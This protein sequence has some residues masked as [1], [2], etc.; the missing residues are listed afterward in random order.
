MHITVAKFGGSENVLTIDIASDLSLKDLKAV[1]EAESDFGIKADEMSLFYEGKFLED[2]SKTLAQC[3]LNDYDLITCQRSTLRNGSMPEATTTLRRNMDA[4]DPRQLFEMLRSNSEMLQQIRRNSPQLVDAIQRGDFN[5][6]MEQIAAQSPEMQQRMELDRLASLD[7]FDPEVQRRIHDIINMQ[8]VQENMEHAVEHAP[9]VFGH[10]AMLYINCKVN[11][12]VVKAFVDSGAQ[13]T[14][15]SKA[16]A[17]RCGIMRLVDRRFSGIAKG[18]GTQ[19]ILGRIHLA[20]LEIEK[21]YFATS[22]SVLEDQ[23]MDMLLGLDMLR[24]HQCVLDLHKN[25]LRIGNVVETSFLPESELPTHARLSGNTPDVDDYEFDRPESPMQSTKRI[26]SDSH[27]ESRLEQSTTTTST[28]TSSQFPEDSIKHI[29]KS[30]F[31]REQ[32]IEELRLSNG[33]ATKALVSLMTKS[34]SVPKRKR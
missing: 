3:K 17:E 20:Q 12:H 24:R 28:S 13:M 5:K 31:T 30:G 25:I 19:K 7:P 2:D 11:G 34:L 23:P 15:M 32:A 27:H 29:T 26:R 4:R 10:V 9:E 14:I 6:F 8:N 22:L 18:V 16:C 1:I 21:N 33:D